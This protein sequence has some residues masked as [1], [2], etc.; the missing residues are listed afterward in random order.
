MSN[1]HLVKLIVGIAIIL[2]ASVALQAF[3]PSVGVA[4]SDPTDIGR[5]NLQ[6]CGE[7]ISN[8]DYATIKTN[9][10]YVGMGDLHRFEAQPIPKSVASAL[11]SAYVGIGDLRRYEVQPVPNTTASACSTVYAGM[12]DLHRLEAQQTLTNTVT[13]TSSSP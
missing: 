13:I 8:S 7:Q 1:N 2:A 5:R 10:P 3:E 9:Q 4:Y 11:S 6:L 12:G